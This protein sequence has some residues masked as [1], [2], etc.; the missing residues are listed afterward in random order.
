[1]Q[2]GGPGEVGL[3]LPQPEGPGTGEL[4]GGVQ[5]ILWGDAQGDQIP[6]IPLEGFL[7]CFL[8]NVGDLR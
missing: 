4:A 3:S 8:S 5:E 2:W 1:M 6:L 7:S